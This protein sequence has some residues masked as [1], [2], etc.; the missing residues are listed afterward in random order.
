M[1]A[2]APAAYSG[3]MKITELQVRCLDVPMPPHRTAAGVVS[4]SPL[5]LLT[6]ATDDGWQGHS[7]TFTYT[8][9]ALKP[10]A[11]FLRN[12]E[13]LVVGQAL[14]PAA[15]SDELHSRFRLLGTQ[16]LVGMALAGLDMAL[17]DALARSRELPLARLLG[18]NSR[19]AR[20]Y[21]G[22]GFDGAL[23]T[24]RAGEAWARR[25]LRG[26]KAKIGYPTLEEDLAVI[27]ALRAAVGPELAV[28]VDYNQSLSPTEAERR[29]RALDGEGLH[30]IEE[31]VA[32]HDFRALARLAGIAATPLQAG[33]NWWGPLDF[34]HAFDAG[35]R[36]HVMADVMKGGGVTGWMRIAAL[37]QVHGTPVS[38]HLWPELSA[39]LLAATPT[40]LWL[41]YANWWNPVLRQPL[42]LR[43]G[44]AWPSA[45]P[46]SGVEFDEAAVAKYTL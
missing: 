31:P 33:E 6:V 46:G 37:A 43:E 20:A 45:G 32:A 40:G 44:H 36:D 14:A 25:G 13:P 34:R 9:A 11:D 10:T 16:G 5:V 42:E 26:V 8:A 24:A 2:A 17:W 41:E 4:S 19:P 27:R 35:V 38:S 1:A 12:L 30:W 28:M 29:L 15:L 23:G 39:Q 18:G 3:R 22:I 7:M 21:G